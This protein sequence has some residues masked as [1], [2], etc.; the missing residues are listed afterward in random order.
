MCKNGSPFFEFKK[1]RKKRKKK[2][3][4]PERKW[5]SMKRG[6]TSKAQTTPKSQ[7]KEKEPARI[8]IPKPRS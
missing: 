5:R 3:T 8:E 4:N 6:L 7:K 2:T 1:K